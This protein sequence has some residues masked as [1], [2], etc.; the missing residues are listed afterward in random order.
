MT[1]IDDGNVL[2]DQLP[3]RGSSL[4]PSGRRPSLPVDFRPRMWT[5]G[6]DATLGAKPVSAIIGPTSRCGG[7]PCLRKK[8]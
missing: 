2:I 3:P 4:L 5:L 1:R 6:P 8:S 7:E